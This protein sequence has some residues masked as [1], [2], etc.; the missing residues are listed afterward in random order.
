ML[1]NNIARLEYEMLPPFKS[2]RMIVYFKK[3]ELVDGFLMDKV[4]YKVSYKTYLEKLAKLKQ[5]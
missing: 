3:P 2:G 1:K 4:A 5:Q